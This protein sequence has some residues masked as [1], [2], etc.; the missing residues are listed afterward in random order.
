MQKKILLI[1]LGLFM[2]IV[3]LEGIL[4]TCVLIN[5]V[6]RKCKNYVPAKKTNEYRILCLG[7]STTEAYVAYFKQALKTRF[8]GIQFRVFNEGISGTDTGIILTN[9]KGNLER[10]KPDI[11]IAMMGLN[12]NDLTVKYEDRYKSQPV[13]QIFKTVYLF[14]LLMVHVKTKLLERS[15]FINFKQGDK[16]TI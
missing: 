5:T 15:F 12:D 13:K 10:Y 6:I 1:F 11:V 9:L 7:E 16:K 3:L 2:A 4:N 8:S 14:K